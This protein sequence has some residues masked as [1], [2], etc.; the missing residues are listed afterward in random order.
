MRIA[1]V[2]PLYNHGNTVAAV[3][4]KCKCFLSD[5]LVI[6]DGSSDLTAGTVAQIT[7]A[8]VELIRLERN[9]GK[10]FALKT[11]AGIL[12][13][14][15][16]DYMITLDAD[17]QHD[18]EDIPEFLKVLASRNDSVI[19][20]CR[21]FTAPNVPDSSK[22]GRK[23]SNFW[24]KLETGHSCGDTQSGFRA[25]PVAAVN[26]L[27]LYC[28][29]YNFEIEVLVKL[30]WAG[31]ECVDLPIRVTYLPGKKRISHFR[32][33]AD[34]WRISWLHTFLVARQ[35]LFIPHKKLIVRPPEF[36]PKLLRHPLKLLRAGFRENPSP[37]MLGA[38]A[39]VG[40]FLAVLPL[41]ALH[42]AVILYVTV[43]LKLD[44][45]M[46]LSFQNIFMPP[47]VP[48]ICIELGYFLRHGHFLTD[49][50]WRNWSVELHLRLWEWTLGSLLLAPVFAAV[51]YL[52]VY[53]V[54]KRIQRK[55]HE[56]N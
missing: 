22:F 37:E 44:R 46:A 9:R 14:R 56:Q 11:A 35:L 26:S 1:G 48:F 31:Y 5:V 29:R 7:A 42:T 53:A 3:A 51:S 43:K 10:G 4:E 18:P 2:I 39:A 36:D 47:V 40:S 19:V 6:D 34:N 24:V 25:Y 32:K 21:D 16:F 52:V 15:G 23:F 28:N 33:G 55:D 12:A 38:S 27:K 54:A 17:G 41:F 50:D 13:E 20:G 8:G 45:L 30:L 49:M